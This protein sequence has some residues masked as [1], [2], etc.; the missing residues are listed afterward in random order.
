MENQ[1]KNPE[2]KTGYVYKIIN[3]NTDEIYIGSSKYKI[4][5]RFS[6]HKAYYKSGI[7]TTSSFKIFEGINPQIILIEEFKYNKLSELRRREGEIQKNTPKCINL[8][9]AGR[10]KTDQYKCVSCNKNIKRS[11]NIPRHNRTSKHCKSELLKPS[12][13]TQENIDIMIKSLFTHDKKK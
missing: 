6:N 11:D 5:K 3:D 1:Q 4:N 8:R 7:K 9:L 2:E 13:M 12:K 10:I